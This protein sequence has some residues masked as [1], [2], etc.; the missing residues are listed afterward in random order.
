MTGKFLALTQFPPFEMLLIR[1]LF[2]DLYISRWIV[3]AA[4]CT[5]GR[6]ADMDNKIIVLGVHHLTDGIW[7]GIDSVINHPSHHVYHNDISLVKT[8]RK[9]HF[10][11]DIRPIKISKQV[12]GESG[13][14]LITG[15][16]CHDE[17]GWSSIY[18]RYLY[19]DIISNDI[20]YASHLQEYQQHIFDTTICT[21]GARKRSS[22]RG[23]SGGPLVKDRKLVGVIS[24]G[25]PCKLSN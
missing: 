7:Y 15:W 6:N 18:L 22:C 23:D 4:H 9:V 24:W 25:V 16:G 2:I 8:D 10:T 3:T 14:A 21:L 17:T 5:S 20:C 12:V 19:V 1:L 13:K 11:D